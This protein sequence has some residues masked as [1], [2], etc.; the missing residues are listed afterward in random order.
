MTCLI[1]QSIVLGYLT[2]FFGINEPTS[3]ETRNAYLYAAGELAVF[4]LE[5]PICFQGEGRGGLLINYCF[6]P[7]CHNTCYKFIII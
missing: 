5:V 4:N 3:E 6:F 7:Q 2:E 1:A